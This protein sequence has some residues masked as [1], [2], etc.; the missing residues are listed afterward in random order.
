MSDDAMR[1][2][3]N[4]VEARKE[5]EWAVRSRLPGWRIYLRSAMRRVVRNKRRYFQAMGAQ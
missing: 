3:F 5:A 4:A 2:Y 1:F